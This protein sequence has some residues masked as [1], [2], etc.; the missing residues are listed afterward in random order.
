MDPVASQNQIESCHPTAGCAR[1]PNNSLREGGSFLYTDSRSS[2]LSFPRGVRMPTPL[3]LPVRQQIYRLATVSHLSP[4][5]IS[6]RLDVPL[7]TVQA[8]LQ[9]CRLRGEAALAP[10]YGARAAAPSPLV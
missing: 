10:A 6:Q 5:T 3:P 1:N 8:L 2:F 9:R 7:R 4:R